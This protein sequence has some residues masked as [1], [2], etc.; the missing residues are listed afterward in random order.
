[1]DC[2]NQHWDENRVFCRSAEVSP[3]SVTFARLHK[4]LPNTCLLDKIRSYHPNVS[5]SLRIK[6][7]EN[8]A[9][10]N[11]CI[12]NKVRGAPFVQWRRLGRCRRKAAFSRAFEATKLCR[13]ITPLAY[14]PVSV[15]QEGG[16]KYAGR[17]CDSRAAQARA[18]RLVL[19]VARG[20][21][22]RS[23]DSPPHRSWNSRR[24]ENHR[25]SPQSGCRTE[26]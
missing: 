12:A 7:R 2:F 25:L 3:L 22:R 15:V 17:K 4:M 16:S 20:R 19:Q 10:L 24:P 11:H 13:L 6:D 18:G 1:M 9:F 8:G 14:S 21:T 5:H 26:T 23:K